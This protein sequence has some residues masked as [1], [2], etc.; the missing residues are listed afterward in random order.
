VILADTT[1][2][3]EKV[4]FG[5]DIGMLTKLRKGS[6]KFLLQNDSARPH[7]GLKTSEQNT[8][9]CWTLLPHPPSVLVFHPQ[10]LHLFGA[11]KD[12]VCGMNLRV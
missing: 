1:P 7:T 11:L 8:K 12:A 3:E 2:R 9:F 5:I 6:S 10:N 4:N